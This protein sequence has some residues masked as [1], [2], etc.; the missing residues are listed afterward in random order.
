MVTMN[1]SIKEV[2]ETSSRFIHKLETGV[3][4]VYDWVSGPPMTEHERTQHS[5]PK[6]RPSAGSP[7]PPS[8][9]SSGAIRKG[10]HSAPFFSVT[11]CEMNATAPIA[12]RAIPRATG[13][14]PR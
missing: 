9:P 3:V 13:A 1:H 14:V 5:W 7:S 4:A 2:R 6:P 10:A 8:N 12:G 11:Q